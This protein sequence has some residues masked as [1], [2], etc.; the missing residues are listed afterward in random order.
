MTD[1]EPYNILFNEVNPIFVNECY[2]LW[3][4]SWFLKNNINKIANT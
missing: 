3:H 1:Y 4:I 2:K